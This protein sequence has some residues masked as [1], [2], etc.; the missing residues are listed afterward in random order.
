MQIFHL[1]HGKL[2]MYM[3]V[4]PWG[5]GLGGL[6]WGVEI[7]ERLHRFKSHKTYCHGPAN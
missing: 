5:F 2:H 1:E 4:L 6:V 7:G 3:V